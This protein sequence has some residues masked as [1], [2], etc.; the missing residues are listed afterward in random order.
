MC[1]TPRVAADPGTVSAK[2]CATMAAL[3]PH[4]MQQLGAHQ[5]QALAA[6]WDSQAAASAGHGSSISSTLTFV[7]PEA[8]A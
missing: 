7:P 3:V 5:Q 6:P 1:D 8:L 4:A 2:L